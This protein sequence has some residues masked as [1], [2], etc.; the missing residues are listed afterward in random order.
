MCFSDVF[1]AC[2]IKELKIIKTAAEA[3]KELPK[4][5]TPSKLS[6]QTEEELDCVASPGRI[7]ESKAET[8]GNGANGTNFKT[9]SNNNNREK[10]S[11]D[12]R[13][14]PTKDRQGNDPSMR[15]SSPQRYT[16]TK[17]REN[18]RRSYSVSS[19]YT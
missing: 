7:V 8:N 3:V 16:P 11:N 1:S 15:I 5:A 14:T 18:G 4:K 9:G 13:L 17:D 2:D 12:Y 19:R 6:K 10:Y